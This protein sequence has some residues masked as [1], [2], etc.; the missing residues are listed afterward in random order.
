MIV[1]ALVTERGGAGAAA[2]EALA[3]GC[4]LSSDVTQPE[5]NSP[6]MS[7]TAT[8]TPAPTSPLPPTLVL[9]SLLASSPGATAA[10]AAAE[11]I[12]GRLDIL[13]LHGAWHMQPL[14]DGAALKKLLPRIPQG[15]AFGQVRASVFELSS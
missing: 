7:E 2:V 9:P 5:L 10:V 11:C 15:P 6:F 3:Q 8:L 13:G 14:L 4:G 12:V 1:V